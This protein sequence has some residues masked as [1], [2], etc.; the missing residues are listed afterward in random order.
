MSGTVS[1]ES[2]SGSNRIPVFERY[3]ESCDECGWS[4]DNSNERK[5]LHVHHSEPISEGGGNGIGN[6]T[7]LCRDCHL[8]VHN[9]SPFS[10]EFVGYVT[11]QLSKFIDHKN[12]SFDGLVSWRLHKD[13]I[14][15]YK[16]DGE[17]VY[18]VEGLNGGDGYDSYRV[19][20][21]NRHLNMCSCYEHN[22]GL[23]RAR[24]VCS[25]VGAALAYGIV[26][27]RGDYGDDVLLKK[28]KTEAK[29]INRDASSY[30]KKKDRLD[31][32]IPE[33]RE[34]SG[35][36]KSHFDSG[37]SQAMWMSQ[38]GDSWRCFGGVCEGAKVTVGR[39]GY[40]CSL[41]GERHTKDY[42]PCPGRMGAYILKNVDTGLE[43]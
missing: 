2:R 38:F 6:L 20:L 42:P 43:V 13:S 30:I 22:F 25:H 37:R 33:L 9:E 11:D 23:S 36:K 14:Y 5:F 31:E 29:S 27:Q 15:R 35:F 40:T 19:N 10:H 21:N 12:E 3:G 39:D 1:I 4:P 8:G 28:A 24:N 16:S 26:S 17:W 34:N 41:D 18:V 32:Q 7:P